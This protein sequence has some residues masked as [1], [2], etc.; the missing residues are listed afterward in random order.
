MVNYLESEDSWVLE[1]TV[2]MALDDDDNNSTRNII[3]D[4]LGVWRTSVD[5]PDLKSV[6][7]KLRGGSS[8]PNYPTKYMWGFLGILMKYQITTEYDG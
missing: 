8:P 1:E 4:F 7:Q 2:E 5:A 6:E 3:L